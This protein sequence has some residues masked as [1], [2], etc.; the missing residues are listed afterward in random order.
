MIA[1]N[2][3]D[4]L[5]MTVCRFNVFVIV[6]LCLVNLNANQESADKCTWR[7]CGRPDEFRRCKNIENIWV[8]KR[9]EKINSVSCKT[10]LMSWVQSSDFSTLTS[11]HKY[12][13][14][15]RRTEPL[16]KYT[17]TVSMCLCVF[18][19]I[20]MWLVKSYRLQFLNSCSWTFMPV[21]HPH[22]CVLVEGGLGCVC[23]SLF[24]GQ[25][26]CDWRLEDPAESVL[27]HQAA[28]MGLRE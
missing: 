8:K 4:M 27:C 15:I 11:E 9:Q 28:R 21:L 22:V 10:T 16:T 20:N 3:T 7:K 5:K 12:F 14:D 23:V 25:F 17:S 13:T 26:S 19:S 2:A 1:V 24:S 18:Q 6:I